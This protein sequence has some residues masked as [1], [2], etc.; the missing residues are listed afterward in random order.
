MAQ[1]QLV[2][3]N[4]ATGKSDQGGEI[5]GKKAIYGWGGKFHEINPGEI[6]M[7]DEHL[8]IHARKH[9]PWLELLDESMGSLSL[10]ESEAQIAQQEV[11]RC[12]AELQAKTVE[13][14]RLQN[15]LIGATGKL[16]TEQAIRE[17]ELADIR[18]GK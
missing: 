8:A 3:R 18:A 10:A 9:N 13:L 4:P 7:L 16:K 14:K 2:I 5:P 11:D 17:K 1:G 6:K 12:T 15:K